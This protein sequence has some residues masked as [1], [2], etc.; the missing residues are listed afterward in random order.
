MTNN[1]RGERIMKTSKVLTSVAVLA[2]LAYAQSASAAQACVY[3][4][5]DST[6]FLADDSGP[7]LAYGPISFVWEPA[8][9]TVLGGYYTERVSDPPA[10]TTYFNNVTSGDILGPIDPTLAPLS[11]SIHSMSFAST[12]PGPWSVSLVSGIIT[13]TSADA[14]L[15]AYDANLSLIEATGTVVCY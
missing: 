6:Y 3:Y 10:V 15:Q 5:S 7:Q 12:V 1:T 9:N 8:T 4:A 14:L 2:T 13:G 11:L